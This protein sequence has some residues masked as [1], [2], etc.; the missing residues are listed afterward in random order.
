MG[1]SSEQEVWRSPQQVHAVG[2]SPLCGRLPGLSPGQDKQ[3]QL[4]QDHM[5]SVGRG[6]HAAIAECQHQ[7]KDR[8]WNCSAAALDHTL[9]SNVMKVGESGSGA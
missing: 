6:A 8:R 3:C 9:F 5:G 1:L 7:F 4:Y 2:S